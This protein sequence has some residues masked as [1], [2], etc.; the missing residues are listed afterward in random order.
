MLLL[1]LIGKAFFVLDT[2][3]NDVH[4]FKELDQAKPS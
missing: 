3:S 1:N 2:Q 4:L